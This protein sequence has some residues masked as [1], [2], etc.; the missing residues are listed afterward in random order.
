MSNI[1][2][3]PV[4]NMRR[5]RRMMYSGYDGNI[6]KYFADKERGFQAA[7]NATDLA[8]AGRRLSN[9]G[10]TR[11]IDQMNRNVYG[12]GDMGD[13]GDWTQ[14]LQTFVSEVGKGIGVRIGGGTKAPV[15]NITMS[16]PPMPTWAKV[17]LGVGAAGAV[18]LIV[19]RR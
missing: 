13:M 18:Y 16:A 10:G 17:A 3:V 5:V 15:T 14:V 4:G 12:L 9:A 1:I 6:S 2:G 7:K 19:K 8:L 11:Y